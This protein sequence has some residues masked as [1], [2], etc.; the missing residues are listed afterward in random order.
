MAETPQQ[1]DPPVDQAPAP[2][3]LPE[4]AA[5]RDPAV[6]HVLRHDIETFSELDLPTVG[7]WK[8]AAHPSTEVLCM[9]YAVDDEPTQLWMPGDPVP[10]EFI[11]AANWKWTVEAHKSSF[12]IAHAKLILEPRFDFPAIPIE[13]RRCSMAMAYAAALPGKLEKVV[14]VLDLPFPKDKVGAT[15]MKRMCKPL[16]DGGRIA[17]AESFARLCLYC[18]RDVEAERAVSKALLPLTADEQKL[19]ELDQH[20]NERGFAV[21]GALL[22]AAHRLVTTTEAKLQAEFRELTGLDSTNQTGK[23]IAWLAAHD[24]VVTDVQKSTLGH[25]LRRKNLTPDVRRAIE[26]RAQLAHASAVKVTA[27][28]AWRGADDRV[29]GTLKFHGA[30]TGRWAGSGPQPQNFKRDSAGMDAKITAVMAGGTGLASPIEAVGDIA[31]GLIVAAPG[32]RLLLGDFSGIESRVLAY[33]SGQQSKLDQWAKFD[34][35]GDPKD[36]PYFIF[37]RACGLAEDA[38][39]GIGKT[40]DLS[41]GY[42][43]AINAWKNHAPDDD[44]STDEDILRYIQ[45]WRTRHPFTC[46]FWK[47]IN[48]KAITAV[49]APGTEVTYKRLH[50][51]SDGKFLRITL[52][53]GRALSYPFPRIEI[54][55]KYGD[56]RVVFKDASM[57]KWTDCRFG[58]GAYGGLWTENLVSGIAR[59]LL[60]AAMKRLEAAGYPIV[61]TVHDEIVC[62]VQD[63]FG[64]LEEFRSLITTLPDWATGTLPIAAKVRESQRFIKSDDTK[65]ETKP[66]LEPGVEIIFG[67]DIE[68]DEDEPDVSADRDELA[69]LIGEIDDEDVHGSGENDESEDDGGYGSADLMSREP[70]SGVGAVPAGGDDRLGAAVAGLQAAIQSMRGAPLL[71]GD[72]EPSAGN[73]ATGR[74]RGGNG[75]DQGAGASRGNGRGGS[76]KILC[77]FHPDHTPSLQLYLD[78]DDPHF[79]CFVC[80]RHGPLDDLPEELMVA[81][82]NVTPHQQ[83]DDAAKL[84][85]AHRFWEQAQPIAGTLAARYLS[86]VRG[87]DINAL[88]P[89]IETVLRFHSACPFNG[90]RHPCLL[91]LFRDVET[92]EPAGIH[93]IALTPDA[94]K[95]DRRM[96]GRWSWPRAI[97][98]WPLIGSRVAVKP[99]YLGEGI[100]TTLAAATRL[101]DHGRPMWP[102]WAAGTSGNIKKFPMVAGVEELVLLVDHGDAGE[103]ACVA[104]CRK[105]KAAGRRARRLRT[106]DP[107][108]N[109][110]NDFVRAKLQIVS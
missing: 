10:S 8:Y 97:K 54:G 3:A 15:L 36:E 14:E 21:D 89:D 6:P 72:V 37:G 32:R 83:A 33:V 79:H 26:L 19:W 13:R 25:A 73:G 100:E 94:Q 76:Y 23:F 84:A 1:A 9:A 90:N 24:C 57:G 86:E 35:T 48:N 12:E 53:S 80:G 67:S 42:Q 88:S 96:L 64:S 78:E 110:F 74:A 93:R 16:P 59:D 82:L 71:H 92:D 51:V 29:R 95:I 98:L 43:G 55:A 87:I 101:R 22:E 17:D 65:P 106:Q 18:R 81:A 103:E 7:H 44:Q 49:R 66:K 61:L 34:R 109:D 45:S 63:G 2:H 47:G 11:E 75:Y 5:A 46:A 108:I 60:A 4:L 40:S 28:L 38:A 20:I 39:R 104:C 58:Q 91:A 107:H 77:P 27:L 69:N 99:L 102:A 31:R 30:S 105:W 68:P 62:E 50:L 56:P 70:A 85:D 41:L 52:P